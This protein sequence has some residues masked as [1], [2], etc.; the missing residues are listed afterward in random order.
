MSDLIADRIPW[1]PFDAL[2]KLDNIV[3]PGLRVLEWGSG[4]QEQQVTH[5]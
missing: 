1:V 2:K 4:D 5:A 3:R